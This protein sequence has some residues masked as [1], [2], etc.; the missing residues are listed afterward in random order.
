MAVVVVALSAASP[1][2]AYDTATIVCRLGD[3]RIAESSGVAS[4]SVSNRW[5]F[6][7]NDSGDV[8]RYF[9]VRVD[10]ATLATFTL[11]RPRGGPVNAVDWEDMARGPDESGRSSLWFGDIGDNA[12]NRSFVALFRVAEPVVNP[13]Q[14]NLS[15]ATTSY[16]RFLL[17]Y[18]DGPHDAEALLVHPTT[19]EVFIVTKSSTGASAVYAAPHP[20]STAEVNVLHRVADLQFVPTGTRGG[21]AIPASVAQVAV[22]GGA[23]A[24]DGSRVVLRT[25]TDAYE[26]TIAGGDVADAFATGVPARTPLPPTRQG[27][28][29]GYTRQSTAI[30]TTTEGAGTPVHVLR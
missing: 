3:T 30:M 13:E 28:A 25:Y 27:E 24:P 10:G 8:G 26:W 7:H 20:L 6:T 21:G 17:S 19:G 12:A 4:S 2:A 15:V 23:I 1:A 22:T 9:A 5:F 18:E 11:T 29:I 14:T 16:T